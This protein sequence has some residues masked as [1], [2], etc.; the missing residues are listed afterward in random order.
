MNITVYPKSLLEELWQLDKQRFT[1]DAESVPF[2]LRCGKPL[3]RHLPVNAMSC[4]ADVY[5]CQA[6]GMD[7]ALRD[8]VK[9]PLPLWEWHV[10]AS[11]RIGLFSLT[12]TA[13][14]SNCAFEHIFAEPKK[15]FPLSD[16]DH[17]VSE[18]AYSRSFYDGRQWFRTWFQSGEDKLESRLRKEIDQFSDDLLAMPEFKTLRAME[19]MCLSCAQR[20][21]SPTD[22]NLFSETEHFCIWLQMVTRERDY[23]LYVHFY[24]KSQIDTGGSPS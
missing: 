16:V 11:E 4:Y 22:F 9:E 20:T 24:Q 23:N 5:I 19:R 3:D 1:P 6:C 18:V 10:A 2:C 13:L 14:V 7:E 15:R 17:P 12:G 21:A 8:A